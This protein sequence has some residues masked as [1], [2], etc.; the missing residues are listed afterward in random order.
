MAVTKEFILEE[1]SILFERI[2]TDEAATRAADYAGDALRS[3]SGR[4]AAKAGKTK[5]KALKKVYED[6]SQHLRQV[7]WGI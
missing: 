2:I 3:L 6:V 4:Y 7:S 1:L 5:D